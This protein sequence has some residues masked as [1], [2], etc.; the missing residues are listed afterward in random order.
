VYV[1]LGQLD[2]S[3][4][5]AQARASKADSVFFFLP[6]GMGISFIKQLVASGLS[7]DMTMYTPG[8]SGDQDTIKAVGEPML[9]MYN[10]AQWSPDLDNAQNKQFMEDFQK[11]YNRIPTMYAAQGYD[12]AMLLDGAIRK[13]NGKIEDKDAFR[14]ALA[15]A[16]FKA[17]QGNF[18][19]NNNHYPIQNY[20]MR[21][22][23][24]NDKGQI[25]NKTVGT[26]FTDY[27]DRYATECKM[28]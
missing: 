9:G 10:A 13:V 8:F 26:V 24:K 20:Y 17:V 15:S 4:E 21:L 7:K 22:I 14:A 28:K 27:H 23:Y 1:K 5:I 19:F 2:Y 16:P 25:T 6:G 12:S 11:T 3:A 18:K